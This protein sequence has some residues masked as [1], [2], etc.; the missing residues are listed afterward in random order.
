MALKLICPN[1]CPVCLCEPICPAGA[2]SVRERKVYV[3]TDECNECGLCR[4]ICV[5]LTPYQALKTR[6]R[7][8]ESL[9]KG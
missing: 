8:I 5:N 6:R 9:E 3:D 7:W 2:I 4:F 1:Y